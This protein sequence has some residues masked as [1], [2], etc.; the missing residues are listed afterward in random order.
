MAN[1]PPCIYI[2][3][4][5]FFQFVFPSVDD[6]RRDLLVHENEHTGQQGGEQG[7]WNGPDWVGPQ[8]GNEPAT[9]V[10]RWLKGQKNIY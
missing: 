10:P 1:G 7:E 2:Y 3:K 4:F 5:A 9:A 8:R 6:D